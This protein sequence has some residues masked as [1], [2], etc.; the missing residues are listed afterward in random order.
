MAALVF[1]FADPKNIGLT[2]SLF[3][4][5]RLL[6]VELSAPRDHLIPVRKHTQLV[7]GHDHAVLVSRAVAMVCKNIL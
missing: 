2:E 6:C 3:H 7:C 5:L 1:T 4:N